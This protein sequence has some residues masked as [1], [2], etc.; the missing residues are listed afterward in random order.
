MRNFRNLC[1]ILIC[2]FTENVIA[3]ELDVMTQN[4]YLGADLS[5]LLSAVE[6]AVAFNSA[7]IGVLKQIAANKTTERIEALAR[8]IAKRHPHLVGLQ[9]V[10]KFG[11]IDNPESEIDACNDPSISGAFVDHLSKMRAAL[12]SDYEDV[13]RVDNLK[14][15]PDGFPLPGL[16]LN[17]DSDESIDAFVT[18]LDRDVIFKRSDVLHENVNLS[19]VC[20]R[21]LKPSSVNGC[22]YEKALEVPVKFGEL[23]EFNFSF[24]RGYVIVDATVKGK[25]YRFVNTHLEV[26]DFPLSIPLTIQTEQALEL[27][28]TLGILP[29]EGKSLIVVGD[30]NSSPQDQTGFPP[31]GMLVPPYQQFIDSGYIDAWTLRPGHADGFTCCQPPHLSNRKSVLNERIDMIFSLEA[32][33]KVRRARVLSNKISSKKRR[34]S[35]RIWSSDHGSVAIKLRYY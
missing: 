14:L 26:K 28:A 30:I 16:P 34:H 15:P 2:F 21:S 23:P 13:A 35:R 3:S 5:P 9:E 29:L 17:I 24:D 7:V 11:C 18:V 33:A 32:P 4:Q 31:Y 27:I 19:A 25:D 22:N 10:Y 1:F 12:G 20:K 8:L 6:D